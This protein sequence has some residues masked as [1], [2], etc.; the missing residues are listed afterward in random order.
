VPAVVWVV[1]HRAFL[2]RMRGATRAPSA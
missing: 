1:T 2:E